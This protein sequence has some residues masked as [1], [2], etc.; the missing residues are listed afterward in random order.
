VSLR[1][2]PVGPEPP[3]LRS[4]AGGRGACGRSAD[5][6]QHPMRRS[7]HQRART[8]ARMT[9]PSRAISA[10]ARTAQHFCAPTESSPSTDTNPPTLPAAAPHTALLPNP[11]PPTPTPCSMPKQRLDGAVRAGPL[12]HRRSPD[13]PP[14]PGPPPHWLAHPGSG[15]PRGV[16]GSRPCQ[17][18]VGHRRTP[19]SVAP[20]HRATTTYPARVADRPNQG[21]G[22]GACS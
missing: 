12:R 20:A 6:P 5:V 1:T 18:P 4:S 2:E 7:S 9:T 10:L 22:A 15:V 17:Q 8:Y 19:R 11:P 13:G 21:Q 16:R 14:E 3:G